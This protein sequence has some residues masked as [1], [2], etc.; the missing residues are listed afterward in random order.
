MGKYKSTI[1]A[2]YIAAYFNDKRE[3]INMTKIQKLTYIAY[4]VFLAVK[5]ER[6]IDEHPQAWPYGPVFPTTRNK[7][8]K[9]DLNSVSLNDED[10]SEIKNDEGVVE[11]IN[12]VYKTFGG[13]TAS[14]LSAWSH[15]EGSPWES[16]VYTPDGVVYGGVIK[17]DIIRSYFRKIIISPTETLISNE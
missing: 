6:L 16:T 10:L 17:D 3:D 13:W 7:L 1:L 11:L 14:R 5:D 9:L 4:G 2:K 12:L 15:R 8:L